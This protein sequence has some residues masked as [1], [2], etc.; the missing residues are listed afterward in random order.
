[1]KLNFLNQSESR[2]VMLKGILCSLFGLICILT[3]FLRDKDFTILAYSL[4]IF[5]LLSGL[6]TL[7]S[8]TKSKIALRNFALFHY[9]GIISFITGALILTFPETAIDLF[10]SI[11]GSVAVGIGLMQIALAFDLKNY[12]VKEGLL[13]YSGIL[14]V[15]L[16]T[17]LFNNPGSISAFLNILLG[18][19]F[20]V[21]GCYITYFAYQAS[22]QAH[23]IKSINISV[24]GTQSNLA[25]KSVESVKKSVLSKAAVPLE[26]PLPDKTVI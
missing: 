26:N 9:E 23:V 15:F 16:G 20:S 13:I 2:L 22:K 7:V 3:I 6:I 19:F 14:T 1:M 11:L 4:G 25:Y 5:A 24:Q 10:M 17:I 18:V 8:I 12:Q 21:V